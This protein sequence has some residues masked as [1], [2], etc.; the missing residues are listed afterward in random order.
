MY[1]L[2]T[3]CTVHHG[4]ALSSELH[5]IMW[6]KVPG[7]NPGSEYEFLLQR[8]LFAMLSM[9]DYLPLYYIHS[10]GVFFLF[11]KILFLSYNNIRNLNSVE[12]QVR[13]IGKI[14]HEE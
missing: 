4:G 9:M 7:S 11:I 12:I 1:Y 3:G 2:M 13:I 8:K 5:F 10:I 14:I 6:L